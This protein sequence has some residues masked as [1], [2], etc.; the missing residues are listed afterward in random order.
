MWSGE[1]PL[2]DGAECRS[3]HGLCCL[4]QERGIAV[5]EAAG[6]VQEVQPAALVLG[7]GETVPFDECWWTTQVLLLS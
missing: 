2:F 1:D 5:Y 4:A 6:G 3:H 7:N